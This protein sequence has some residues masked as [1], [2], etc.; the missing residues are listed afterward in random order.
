MEPK[1][2][3]TMP[4]MAKYALYY[5]SEQ[6][7]NWYE[8]GCF[9]DEWQAKECMLEHIRIHS[10]MDCVIVQLNVVSEYKGWNDGR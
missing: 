1:D 10:D 4:P 9:N 8:E 5:R 7:G 3:P 6:S 2:K